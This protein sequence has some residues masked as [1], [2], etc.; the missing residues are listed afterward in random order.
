MTNESLEYKQLAKQ[1]AAK[2]AA[3]LIQSGMTIGLGTGSTTLFFI[4]YLAKRCREENLNIHAVVSSTQSL[5][6]AQKEKIPLVD[7]NSVNKLD[8]T[9]DGADEI[10]SEKRMIKG[11]GGALLRE[12]IIASMSG[13]MIV[14]VDEE[15]VVKQLGKFPLPLEIAPFGYQATLSKIKQHGYSCTIRKDKNEQ[16]YKT[17]NGN[18][19]FDIHFSEFIQNPEKENQFFKNIPGVLDTGFFFKLAGRVIIGFF[20][21][22]VE[23][24]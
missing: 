13:E 23:I 18:Y 19:I 1:A 8:V 16:I 3:N 22:H 7:I 5:Q 24:R 2:K 4:E 11:G 15:K 14:I 20:D 21:K 17:D 10:D 6:A 9:V 12:K